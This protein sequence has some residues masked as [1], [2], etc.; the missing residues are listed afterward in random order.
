MKLR[1]E[2]AVQALRGNQIAIA[3]RELAG[4]DGWKRILLK[5][6]GQK[7]ASTQRA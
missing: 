1:K 4:L 3:S 7:L 2:L 6:L 5:M